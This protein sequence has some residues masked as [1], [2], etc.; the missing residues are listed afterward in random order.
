MLGKKRFILFLILW[1]SIV[2]NVFC[3]NK[4]IPMRSKWFEIHQSIGVDHNRKPRH[5]IEQ[6]IDSVLQYGLIDQIDTIQYNHLLFVVETS[7]V[8]EKKSLVDS[9]FQIN[10][11]YLKKSN[12]KSETTEFLIQRI[13]WYYKSTQ[14]K[15]KIVH[16]IDLVESNRDIMDDDTRIGLLSSLYYDTYQFEKAINMYDLMI[17]NVTPGDLMSIVS[18]HNNKGLAYSNLK[19]KEEAIDCYQKAMSVLDSIILNEEYKCQENFSDKWLNEYYRLIRNNSNELQGIHLTVEEEI[20]YL[21][22]QTRIG[23]NE[24]DKNKDYY[25]IA[26]LYSSLENYEF[27]NNYL[28]SLKEL[29]LIS[30]FVPDLQSKVKKLRVYN[31]LKLGAPEK[32]MQYLELDNAEEG[33]SELQ[34]LH[35]E[36]N[37]D[38]NQRQFE[39]TKRI[40][41]KESTV[42]ILFK[43]LF[44]SLLVFIIVISWLFIKRKQKEKYLNQLLHKK[45]DATIKL[46]ESHH[47]IMNSIQLISDLITIDY[48]QN[49]NQFD[50]DLFQAK[51]KAVAEIHSTLYKNDDNYI[52]KYFYELLKYVRSIVHTKVSFELDIPKEISIGYDKSQYLGL[53]IVELAINTVKHNKNIKDLN[54]TI[55]LTEDDEGGLLFHYQD[56][57][58]FDRSAFLNS[59]NFGNELTFQLIQL[60]EGEYELENKNSLSLI[61]K[62]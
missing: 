46:K 60:L 42:D 1:I 9:I 27:S 28:D 44:I 13:N 40:N 41:K 33:T 14:Q 30:S 56:N 5:L 25:E 53:L 57:G 61:I 34:N 17:L 52:D 16:L 48:L 11:E 62:F 51:M 23:F 36:I 43:A 37:K 59:S 39:L 19:M 47:R 49:N 8:F 4:E 6:K 55:S 31:Y 32:A 38:H 45:E 15:E 24:G 3:H 22:N 58:I 12:Q 2:Q 54:A 50:L 10:I 26:R 29:Q 20:E 21:I 7:Y 35:R 18:L